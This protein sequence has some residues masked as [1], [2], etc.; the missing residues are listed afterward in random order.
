MSERSF[1]KKFCKN[2]T[3]QFTQYILLVFIMTTAKV[4][5]N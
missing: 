3:K 1:I 5:K 2:H 4:D